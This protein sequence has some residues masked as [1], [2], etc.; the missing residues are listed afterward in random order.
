MHVLYYNQTKI[1][2]NPADFYH[3]PTH[4]KELFYRGAWDAGE[5]IQQGEPQSVNQR[6]SLDQI[7]GIFYL[8]LAAEK[9]LQFGGKGKIASSWFPRLIQPYQTLLCLP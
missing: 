2:Q 1:Q 6:S 7:K 4:L 8:D 9:N 5:E 3:R